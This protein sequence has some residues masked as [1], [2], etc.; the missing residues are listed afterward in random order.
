MAWRI[1]LIV[2]AVVAI[3]CASLAL[4]ADA[5]PSERRCK[6]TRPLRPGEAGYV[7]ATTPGADPEIAELRN[8][9]AGVCVGYD[10]ALLPILRSG[11]TA[12]WWFASAAVAV[13]TLASIPLLRRARP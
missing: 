6:E 12:W 9:L 7:D 3:A 2:G 5:R 8:E 1:A 10:D 4:Y 13:L 11:T